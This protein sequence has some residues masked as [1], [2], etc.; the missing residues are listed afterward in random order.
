MQASCLRASALRCIFLFT[1]AYIKLKDLSWAPAIESFLGPFLR[2]Y[3]VDSS[4]D[5]AVLT[6]IFNEVLG[7]ERKPVINTS[8]FFDKVGS[9]TFVKN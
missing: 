1:G 7:K 4:H 6:Q 3:C 5:A 2:S 8:R 9:C